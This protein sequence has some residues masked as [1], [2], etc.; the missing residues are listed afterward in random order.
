M[1]YVSS[2]HVFQHGHD[3]CSIK[4]DKFLRQRVE[5]FQKICKGSVRAILEQKVQVFIILKRP[6]KFNHVSMFR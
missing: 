5:M 6:M 2:M 4:A 1:D 3:L